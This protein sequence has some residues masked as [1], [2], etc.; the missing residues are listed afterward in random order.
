[1]E[2]LRL[3]LLQPETDLELFKTSWGWRTPKGH[4]S[5]EQMPFETY[6]ATNATHLTV[7]LFNGEL[8][9]VYF[10][11]EWAPLRYEGHFTSKRGVPRETLLVGARAI[12]NGLLSNGALEVSALIRPA[13][14][15]LRQFVTDLGMVKV[16]CVEFTCIEDI[17]QCIFYAPRNQRSKVYV[18][19]VKMKDDPLFGPFRQNS[20]V[21]TNPIGAE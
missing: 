4:I 15:P 6:S 16:G 19:Y 13:N 7:G 1:M 9:A 18:K 2:D 10:F 17:Q 5:A 21:H 8:I 11:V 14:K 3:Q 12:L 20:E